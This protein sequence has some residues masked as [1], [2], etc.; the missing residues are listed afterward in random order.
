MMPIIAIAPCSKLHDYEEAVRRAGGEPRVLDPAADHP[1]DVVASV[2]G[3]L[4]TGGGDVRPVALRRGRAPDVRRRRSP[5][6][7]S[8]RSSWSAAA[9]DADLPRVRHLPRHPGAERRARRHA[10]PGHP[11]EVASRASTTRVREPPASRIAHDVWMAPG[12]RCSTACCARARRR[13]RLRRQQPAPPGGQA[14]RRGPRRH[15]HRARRRHRSGRGSVAS[16]SASACSGTRRTS[17]APASS[18]RCS[19]VLSRTLRRQL[20]LAHRHAAASAMLSIARR[21]L[22]V[23]RVREQVEPGQRRPARSPRR[24]ARARRARAWRRRT[25]RR[26]SRRAPAR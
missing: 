16:A 20:R 18:R 26:R 24:A 25:T 15:R 3:L 19:R 6:A 5:A 17:T 13:R 10:G 12:S 8:T 22:D 11:D 2:D 4:L 7:T 21:A 9:L 14:T 1:A 23:R